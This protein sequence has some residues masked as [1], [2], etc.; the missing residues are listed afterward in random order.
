MALMPCRECGKTVSTEAVSCPQ[1]GAVN[2][3]R[4]PARQ[5]ASTPAVK[6]KPGAILRGLLGLVLVVVLVKA[7]LGSSDKPDGKSGDDGSSHVY[8]DTNIPGSTNPLAPVPVPVPTCKKD[9]HACKDNADVVN[10]Y[11]GWSMVQVR[12]KDSAKESAK[13]GTPD[14]PWF[15]FGTFNRG[16]DYVKTGIATSI[17]KDAQFSNGFG[18]MVHTRIVCRYDL[19]KGTVLN[20]TAQPNR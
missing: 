19:N 15:S 7:F 5:Q 3:T 10:T 18:A 1:C 13:Y 2:P 16:E 8:T 4:L 17:E 11:E 12:C 20:V 9:W 6:K 14:F